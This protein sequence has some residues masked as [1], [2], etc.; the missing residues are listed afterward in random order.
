VS[1]SNEA[2]SLELTQ[3]NVGG[4]PDFTVPSPAESQSGCD[5]VGDSSI[6]TVPPP[7]C[8]NARTS[9]KYSLTYLSSKTPSIWTI[10][11]VSGTDPSSLCTGLQLDTLN[12]LPE[13]A[14][15]AVV[16][17]TDIVGN[18]NVSAPLRF[19]IDRGGQK[20]DSW[21]PATLPDCT[22]I[23]PRDASAPTGSCKPAPSFLPGE[24]PI[25]SVK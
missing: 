13:G 1:A 20:C 21:P 17:A 3:F 14:A 16:V 25:V 22:G 8:L 6:S 11:P 12:H 15:C 9:M 5:L 18:H 10:P 24:I 4:S 23:L 7:L 19:C 2:L